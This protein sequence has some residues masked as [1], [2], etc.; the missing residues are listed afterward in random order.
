[1]LYKPTGHKRL[2]LLAA[3]LLTGLF[4]IPVPL[5]FAGEI[6]VAVAANFTAAARELA[7]QFEETSG[8]HAR[9]SF[10]S[11]GQLYAQISNGAP[12]DVFLAADS[13]RPQKL[14][15]SKLAVAGSRFTYARGTLVLVS[16]AAG[17]FSDGA[18]FLE[19]DKF[20]RLA[21]A[22]PETAPYGHAAQQVLEK[23]GL[24]QK[25]QHKIVRGNSIAQTYQFVVTGNAEAGFIADSQ[26][27][28]RKQKEGSSF[29]S[30]WLVPEAFYDPIEQQAAL[31]NRDADPA[32]ARDFLDFLKSDAARVIIT[33]YGYLVPQPDANR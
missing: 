24:W 15:S 32:V 13:V 12:F 1:M 21:I 23:L 25:L 26:A 2:F 17:K 6:S 11:T 29:A 5:L 19:A 8:H 10:G 22:N 3:C 9:L 14:E 30:S 31:L 4:V 28:A 18:A 33:R 7:R 16:D 27:V 20:Q